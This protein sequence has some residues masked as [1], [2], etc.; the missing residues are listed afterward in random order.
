MVGLIDSGIGGLTIAAEIR[1]F[2]PG[3]ALAYVADTAHFPYGNR[4]ARDIVAWCDAM[5]RWLMERHDP[6]VL[7]LACNTATAAGVE[8]LRSRF[9]VPIVAVEPAIKPAALASTCGRI[10]V[11]ATA[12]TVASG[13]LERLVRSHAGSSEVLA[14]SCEGLAEALE[15]HWPDLDPIK[16]PL[17]RWLDP[18]LEFGVDT[19]VLGCTHYPLA[20][21]A[22]ESIV[23]PD[24]RVIDS[25]EAVARR[26]LEIGGSLP[27]G[28]VT[29]HSTAEAPALGRVG[30]TITGAPV[31]V[32]RLRWIEGSLTDDA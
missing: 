32:G 13:R 9:D 14:Q 7:V 21:R 25:G 20:R 1:R 2:A 3:A 24:V 8:E 15:T 11:L 23:G 18:L 16:E 30:G 4:D 31:P 6:R 29:L 26:V 10:G 17:R 22:I 28:P 12:H 5:V 19:I 27:T